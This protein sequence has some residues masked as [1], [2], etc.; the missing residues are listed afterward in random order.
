M[1]VIFVIDIDKPII[2]VKC[3]GLMEISAARYGALAGDGGRRKTLRYS[4]IK[5]LHGMSLEKKMECG[6]QPPL[7]SMYVRLC[8]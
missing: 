8:L 1:I 4:K 2:I 6:Q 5:L 3:N 7:T